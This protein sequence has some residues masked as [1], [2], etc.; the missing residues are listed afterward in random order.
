MTPFSSSSRVLP[1]QG[2]LAFISLLS[3]ADLL[4]PVVRFAFFHAALRIQEVLEGFAFS[5][6]RDF[7]SRGNHFFVLHQLGDGLPPLSFVLVVEVAHERVLLEIRDRAFFFKNVFYQPPD[8]FVI[9]RSSFIAH[10]PCGYY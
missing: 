2:A 3:F 7:L 5:V 8:F 10:L 4:E 1:W 6:L 9:Y